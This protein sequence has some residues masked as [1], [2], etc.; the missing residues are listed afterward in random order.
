MEVVGLRVYFGGIGEG[1]QWW[2]RGGERW[3]KDGDMA[4]RYICIV[5]LLTYCTDSW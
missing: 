4:C 5:P 2:R 1:D 3:G